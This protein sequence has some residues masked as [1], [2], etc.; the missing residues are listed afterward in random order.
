MPPCL[1]SA[2]APGSEGP[3]RD[4]SRIDGSASEWGGVGPPRGVSSSG[5][6]QWAARGPLVVT[7]SVFQ[8][9]RGEVC[10]A[11]CGGVRPGS[12]LSAPVNMEHKVQIG[13]HPS[14]LH[15]HTKLTV[16]RDFRMCSKI[17]HGST[18]STSCSVPQSAQHLD[19]PSPDVARDSCYKGCW[20]SMC[21]HLAFAIVWAVSNSFGHRFRQA[22]S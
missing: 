1:V 12:G 21:E 17:L 10:I 2:L 8:L 18:L 16:P 6:P 22:Q 9:R 11:H 7:V 20:T 15:T 19:R 14:R 3:T 13:N 5:A 4:I